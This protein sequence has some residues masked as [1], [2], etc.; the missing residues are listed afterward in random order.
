M[1]RPSYSARVTIVAVALMAGAL[2]FFVR[3]RMIG[4]IPVSGGDSL[5]ITTDTLGR[6]QTRFYSYHDQAGEELRFILGRDSGGQVHAVM[7]ACQ[8]CY[9]YHQGYVSSGDYLVCKFCGNRY[10]L[11]AMESG[12]ASCVPVK[13]P[14]QISRRSVNVKTADLERERG[15]F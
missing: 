15:L 11:E 3:M 5:I 2:L 4:F 6:A 8:R 1:R 9:R 14:A 7:D 12:L 13:L 10:R